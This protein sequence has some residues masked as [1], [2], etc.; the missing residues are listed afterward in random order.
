MSSS[1]SLT[2]WERANLSS[3]SRIWS[4]LMATSLPTSTSKPIW[5]RVL[6]T[7]PIA[8]PTFQWDRVDQKLCKTFQETISGTI[9]SRCLTRS[10][11][12]RNFKIW[13]IS[14]CKRWFQKAKPSATS[15]QRITAIPLTCSVFS[16]FQ[17][18]RSSKFSDKLPARTI[19]QV[20]QKAFIQ[21]ALN[22]L[23]KTKTR[24]KSKKVSTLW[25]LPTQTR[26]AQTK[27]DLSKESIL[28][29]IGQTLSPFFL[30]SSQILLQ[31]KKSSWRKTSISSALSN[32]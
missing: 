6:R 13:P 12:L 11:R 16:A 24:L 3:N 17:Q 23:K 15:N 10:K 7:R 30:T 4:K 19:F 14:R 31:T 27:R 8:E 22:T 21:L 20:P 29:M 1:S 26:T 5:T 25:I 2:K 28:M 18:T 9:L 32:Q